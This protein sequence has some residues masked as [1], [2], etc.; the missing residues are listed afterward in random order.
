MR[1]RWLAV[2]TFLSYGVL[3]SAGPPSKKETPALPPVNALV[4]EYA[5]D[6]LGKKVT[7]GQCTSLA[8]EALREAGAKRLS[9]SGTEGD[10][11]WGRPVESFKDALPGDILQFRDA[12]FKGKRSLSKD[13][14][15]TWRED[16]PHHTAIVVDV[17]E[18]GKVV[19]ILH[20]NTGLNEKSDAEKM[21]VQEGTLRLDALQPGGK[22][23]IYRPV[24]IE[25]PSTGNDLKSSP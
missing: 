12:V 19:K 24:P 5:R 23:W 9:M 10:F 7:N 17:K 14:I 13:R 1:S 3:S 18:R 8:V 11:I 6:H 4:V 21:I 22:I 20:Q 2:L 25:E 15:L 16:Y